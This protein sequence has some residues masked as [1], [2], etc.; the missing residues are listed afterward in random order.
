MAVSARL[1]SG[2]AGSFDVRCKFDVDL[3]DCSYLCGCAAMVEIGRCH[4]RDVPINDNFT[5]ASQEGGSLLGRARQILNFAQAQGA[6]TLKFTGTFTNGPLAAR[7]GSGLGDVFTLTTPATRPGL[8]NL[9]VG[10]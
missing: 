1:W 6:T 9:L 7:F 5:I 10:P 8:I 2:G 4:L 3:A